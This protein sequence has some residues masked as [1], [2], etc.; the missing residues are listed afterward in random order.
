M[1]SSVFSPNPLPSS[2]THILNS[3]SVTSMMISTSAG[4][5]EFFP[6]FLGNQVSGRA[7]V[8]PSLISPSFRGWITFS[9]LDNNTEY[10]LTDKDSKKV[11]SL[12]KPSDGLIQWNGETAEGNRL[13]TGKYDLRK[14]SGEKT[15]VSLNYI[16]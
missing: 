14:S 5:A 8:S 2:L 9:G 1:I 11:V 10:E 4:L 7:N 12:G 3:G 6:E 16:R 13:S 15:G